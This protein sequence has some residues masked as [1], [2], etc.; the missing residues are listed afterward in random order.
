MEPAFW[1]TSALVPLC[2]TQRS[3][4]ELRQL[5]R[6]Y[7][8]V[9]WWATPVEARSA[10][11]RDLRSGI[12]S[13]G[14]HE[15]ALERLDRLGHTW[16][17]IVPNDSLRTLAEEIIGQYPLRAADAFQ[18]AAAYTWSISRPFRR[19]LISGDRRLLGAAQAMGF[20]VIQVSS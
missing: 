10:F 2:V 13:S 18:L 9:V 11:A 8:I 19:H 1:D 7:A 20:R 6:Q 4:Q 17:E 14:E 16:R 3:S 15:M 12:L 5:S